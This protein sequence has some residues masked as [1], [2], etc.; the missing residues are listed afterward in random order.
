[1]RVEGTGAEVPVELGRVH[2]P[3]LP[4]SGGPEGPLPLVERGPLADWQGSLDSAFFAIFRAWFVVFVLLRLGSWMVRTLGRRAR[5]RWVVLQR[6]WPLIEGVVWVLMFM[7]SLTRLE[8]SRAIPASVLV[9]F[10][11]CMLV[12]ASWNALRDVSGGLV[13][14][15]ER[16]FQVGDFVRFGAA[17]GQVRAFRARVVELETVDGHLLRVPYRDLV[18]VTDVRTGGKRTAHAVVLDL[19][20]PESLEPSEAMALAM[21]VAASSP[22]AVL[23]VTPRLSLCRQQD[24]VTKIQVE[25]YAFDREANR[26]LHADLVSGWRQGLKRFSEPRG[27][28]KSSA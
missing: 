25:A 17:S 6:G 14:A 28:S 21:E 1:M 15:S 26:H 20:V 12:A 18:G 10:A 11:A 8:Y 19:D 9:G 16:P 7:W 2:G 3:F 4:D 24:G 27:R 22:W 13:L 23:G 5:P